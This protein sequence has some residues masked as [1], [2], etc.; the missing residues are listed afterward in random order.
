MQTRGIY[1]KKLH[2]PNKAS[3]FVQWRYNEKSSC[4]SSK[5]RETKTELKKKMSV[6]CCRD[7]K[8]P[9]THSLF[10]Y[11]SFTKRSACSPDKL[12][13]ACKRR[14]PSL[15][16]SSAT[17][18][19][20]SALDEVVIF[21]RIP[22][23]LYLLKR[24]KQYLDRKTLEEDTK[25]CGGYAVRFCERT[26]DSQLSEHERRKKT[27]LLQVT[28]YSREAYVRCFLR[29]SA[30]LKAAGERNPFVDCCHEFCHGSEGLVNL[31]IPGA[32][33]WIDI[34]DASKEGGESNG[35]AYVIEHPNRVCC[36]GRETLYDYEQN[37]QDFKLLRCVA[38]AVLCGDEEMIEV[39]FDDGDGFITE[40]RFGPVGGRD[41]LMEAFQRTSPD[42]LFLAR[43]VKTTTDALRRIVGRDGL[44]KIFSKRPEECPPWFA[45]DYVL[46][47][48]VL[49][50]EAL[51][52]R[53]RVGARR[54]L[55]EAR[56][57]RTLPLHL[58][59]VVESSTNSVVVHREGEY[60]G[61]SHFDTFSCN[62]A[63]SYSKRGMVT[64][65][66]S[67][68][69][70]TSYEGGY[71][72]RPDPCFVC[73]PVLYSDFFS[74]YPSAVIAF[75]LSKETY[76]PP[77]HHRL[78]TSTSSALQALVPSLDSDSD[79]DS[80]GD[81]SPRFFFDYGN[82]GSVLCHSGSSDTNAMMAALV[83]KIEERQRA[84]HLT[85]TVNSSPDV[86][87]A[88]EERAAAIKKAVNAMCGMLGNADNV[89]ADR[90][91]AACIT[92]T[93]RRLLV[94]CIESVVNTVVVLGANT[95]SL[96]LC[97]NEDLCKAPVTHPVDAFREKVQCASK[98]LGDCLANAIHKEC[99]KAVATTETVP[100]ATSTTKKAEIASSAS[101]HL[102]LLHKN[103]S[104]LTLLSGK[105]HKQVR[106]LLLEDG[107]GKS[108]AT[109]EATKLGAERGRDDAGGGTLMTLAVFEDEVLIK[110]AIKGFYLVKV[111]DFVEAWD[112]EML[113][114]HLPVIAFLPGCRDWKKIVEYQR[115]DE[116]D[117]GVTQFI[118]GYRDLPSVDSA[119]DVAAVTNGQKEADN[120][121]K[122]A[123]T[124]YLRC[125]DDGRL[126]GAD[127]L[128]ATKSSETKKAMTERR[129]ATEEAARRFFEKM[130][131]FG[132]P[133]LDYSKSGKIYAEG[134]WWDADSLCR[135][136]KPVDLET[137]RDLLLARCV[138]EV[139][140]TACGRAFSVSRPLGFASTTSTVS[141]S[142]DDDSLLPPP[143]TKKPRNVHP[144]APSKPRSRS[145]V[146]STIR[147]R[148][149]NCCMVG[150][151]WMTLQQ[152]MDECKDGWQWQSLNSLLQQSECLSV[153]MLSACETAE[154]TEERILAV[155]SL[156]RYIKRLKPTIAVAPNYDENVARLKRAVSREMREKEIY[157]RGT[158]KKEF[159]TSS[160]VCLPQPDGTF[161]CL[162]RHL[163]DNGRR[164]PLSPQ[165]A[166]LLYRA[167]QSEKWS[168]FDRQ[169]L[170]SLCARYPSRRLRTCPPPVLE[171]QFLAPV[172]SW[173][174]VMMAQSFS[175]PPPCPS[176]S[177]SSFSSP[178]FESQRRRPRAFLTRE[179]YYLEEREE[180][181]KGL[182]RQS[183]T[184]FPHQS[185]G[186]LSLLPSLPP[187]Q[188]HIN[189][190]IR[191]FPF[192]TLYKKSSSG[193]FVFCG[194]EKFFRDSLFSRIV[195]IAEGEDDGES[196]SENESESERVGES[197]DVTE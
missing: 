94:A 10:V 25:N 130:M 171:A 22:Y 188:S 26:V 39:A 194:P 142:N 42:V 151:R 92:A 74:M 97:L 141:A 41:R 90:R 167:V 5:I 29:L 48:G 184:T 67:E 59:N 104:F 51:P 80:E 129:T 11:S 133:L 187:L 197:E 3:D 21:P 172:Q 91:V 124:H 143:P 165:I 136:G 79:S 177:T 28:C 7:C 32:C 102:R 19:A 159:D 118:F 100:S 139:T 36:H 99:E 168:R 61:T 127:F 66:D 196:E 132:F 135:S 114:A 50:F 169:R 107:R 185:G 191:H 89:Y 17:T 115:S 40:Q 87:E 148:H 34:R 46:G 93:A 4:K 45:N 16:S 189:Y 31:G 52:G 57:K 62:M 9:P 13:L 138:D 78:Y 30:A 128:M 121:T 123:V 147:P 81:G 85:Q 20:V 70:E 174:E 69:S 64:A 68:H 18:R 176:P 164:R 117:A 98:V 2:L 180:E 88:A 75:N 182:R 96:L 192:E 154:E 8:R 125:N 181:D 12:F 149:R 162:Q 63:L 170:R 105:V 113:V 111:G 146:S 183:S 95:D 37:A 166:D 106:L 131:R 179:D 109:M 1:K 163:D 53:T 122:T 101:R 72:R 112:V 178:C 116:D 144:S 190:H 76:H 56:A 82:L 103:T 175:D 83:S 160:L 110:V 14:P 84:V 49:V 65:H 145:V 38:I 43:D 134:K 140:C 23:R 126:V 44:R 119:A 54:T 24:C 173:Q 47:L 150:Q 77:N 158:T 55:E 152:V 35:A 27:T 155:S 33:T 120:P 58:A 86:V 186:S 156:I 137:H 153:V 6:T 161:Y 60:L 15:P 193:L 157:A 108:V 73:K 71:V 195:K